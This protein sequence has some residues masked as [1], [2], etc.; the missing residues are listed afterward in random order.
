[1]KKLRSTFPSPLK[2]KVEKIKW[3]K[4][5]WLRLCMASNETIPASYKIEQQFINLNIARYKVVLK[6]KNEG[7]HYWFPLPPQ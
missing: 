7:S 3:A 2:T 6:T 1:M 5:G 4:L